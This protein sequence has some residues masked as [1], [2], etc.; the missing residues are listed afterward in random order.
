MLFVESDF[1]ET[2]EF[3]VRCSNG[4]LFRVAKGDSERMD[5]EQ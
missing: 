1:K 3:D 5:G 2:T 4:H